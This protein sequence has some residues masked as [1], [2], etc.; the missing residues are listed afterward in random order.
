[1]SRARH[2]DYRNFDCGRA[3][4]KRVTLANPDGT[5]SPLMRLALAKNITYVQHVKLSSSGG[6]GGSRA[7]KSSCFVSIHTGAEE[8]AERAARLAL[9]ASA[10]GAAGPARAPPTA[11]E[12]AVNPRAVENMSITFYGTG[13]NF[14]ALL[15]VDRIKELAVDPALALRCLRYFKEAGHEGYADMVLPQ[16]DQPI[17]IV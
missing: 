5:V 4:P 7:L 11:A 1:M 6:S 2:S 15:N 17:A 12:L 13:S 9:L 8:I 16:V 10:A 3:L 14:K